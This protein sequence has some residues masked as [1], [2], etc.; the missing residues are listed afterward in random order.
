MA[1]S[2]DQIKPASM[3]QSG[4]CR[5]S[6]QEVASSIPIGAG[7]ILFLGFSDHE[8]YSMVNLYLLLIQEGQLSVSGQRMCTS[9]G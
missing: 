5:T 8:V 6:D 7:N 2:V 1:N 9:T 3:A 4:A